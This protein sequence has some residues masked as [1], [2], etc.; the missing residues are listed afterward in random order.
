[1][2]TVAELKLAPKDEKMP[3]EAVVILRKSSIRK[4]RND[5]E[6]L[7]TEFGD[8]TGVFHYVC[9]TN[10]ALYNF[11]LN[12]R[13]GTVLR[14]QG[15]TDYYQ[16][17]FSPLIANADKLPDEELSRYLPN[18]VESAPVSLAELWKE[19]QEQI[20]TIKDPQIQATV[21]DAVGEVEDI[22]KVVPGAISMHH[23]YR[24]GLLE[25]TV[26]VTRAARALLPGYPEVD[27]DLATAGCILHDIGKAL[28][29]TVDLATSKTRLGQLQGHVVLGYR[30]T[31]RAALKAGLPENVLDR[32]E[33]IILSHQGELE[34]GAAIK[35]ATP[36]AV[37][38]SMVDNLD[39]KMA[40]VQHALRTTP[41]SS[42]FSEPIGG[43]GSPVLIRKP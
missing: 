15:H 37:F 1:M 38:V 5:S 17:R 7:M 19:L 41:D 35:A 11:F 3:F 43:L 6:F 22:F 28:E 12:L 26:A 42:E 24:C 14:L 10:S 25:H 8:R 31:R 21:K 36:E 4:A 34:W 9:F 13:E 27:P 39:A 32:L 23:A 16:N 30:L 40:M 18:L 20:D 29:Y 2:Q 33:H